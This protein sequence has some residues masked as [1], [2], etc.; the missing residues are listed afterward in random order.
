MNLHKNIVRLN[1][2][3]ILFVV[4]TPALFFVAMANKDVSRYDNFYYKCSDFMTRLKNSY[5]DIDSCN[6]DHL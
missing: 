2:Y 5:P 6:S 4:M 3:L 1:Y